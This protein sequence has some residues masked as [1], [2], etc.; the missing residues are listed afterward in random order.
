MSTQRGKKEGEDQYVSN[1][2]WHGKDI[3]QKWK[4]GCQIKNDFVKV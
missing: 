3:Y 4:V 2:L 1:E